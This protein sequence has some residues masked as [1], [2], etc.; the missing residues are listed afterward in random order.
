[1]QK[2]PGDRG[3][4]RERLGLGD[5]GTNGMGIPVGKASL[6]TACAASIRRP[7]CPHDRCRDQQQRI[8]DDPQLSAFRNPARRRHYDSLLD[9]FMEAASAVFPNVMIQLEDFGNKS[10][11]AGAYR[12]RYCMFDDDIQGPRRYAGRLYPAQDDSSKITGRGLSFWAQRG[13][14]GIG[15]LVARQ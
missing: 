12:D 11:P 1:M 14:A 9:D 4:R 3:D 8:V 7:V 13:G 10:L 15:S 6:Y 5:L 2:R